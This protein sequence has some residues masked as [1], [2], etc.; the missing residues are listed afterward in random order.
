MND[1]EEWI[2][3]MD[4]ESYPYVWVRKYEDKIA[5]IPPQRRITVKEEMIQSNYLYMS[6]EG[7][8][9]D[10]DTVRDIYGLFSD[11]MSL[12][13]L[14]AMKELIENEIVEWRK[15]RERYK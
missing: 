15:S 13:M 2:E 5:L 14:I 6:E 3:W 1:F 11:H 10:K 4:R 7:Q 12:N 8:T 9:S